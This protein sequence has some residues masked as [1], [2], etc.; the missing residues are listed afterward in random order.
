VESGTELVVRLGLLGLECL[1][2]V[3]RGTAMGKRGKG[4]GR[5]GAR[6][7]VGGGRQEMD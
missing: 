3:W 5:K 6:R 7:E 4:R 1:V 2:G